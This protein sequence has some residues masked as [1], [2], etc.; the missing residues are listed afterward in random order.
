MIRS[1]HQLAFFTCLCQLV[2]FECLWQS[3]ADVV[4]WLGGVL[5]TG[6]EHAD[7]GAGSVDHT[8]AEACY[9]GKETGLRGGKLGA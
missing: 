9:S 5:G 4:G 6:E 3:S 2:V 8:A 7:A 1:K